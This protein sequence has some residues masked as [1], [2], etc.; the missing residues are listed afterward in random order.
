M[1][2]EEIEDALLDMIESG[3]WKSLKKVLSNTLSHAASF[4]EDD[5][6]QSYGGQPTRGADDQD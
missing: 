2:P 1:T 3:N 6:D 5:D 4:Y